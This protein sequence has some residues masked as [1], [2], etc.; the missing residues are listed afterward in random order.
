M[1]S[2][3]TVSAM[4][5]PQRAAK[6]LNGITILNLD[7]YSYA[8]FV[9]KMAESSQAVA[10]R[11]CAMGVRQEVV[12]SGV[13]A[14]TRAYREMFTHG[15]KMKRICLDKISA[16]LQRLGL[17]SQKTSALHY[18]L[19]PN[20]WKPRLMGIFDEPIAKSAEII[21]VNAGSL[22]INTNHLHW[23]KQ[24]ELMAAGLFKPSKELLAT[25]AQAKLDRIEGL[26]DSISFI[27]SNNGDASILEKELADALR[28]QQESMPKLA[29]SV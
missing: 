20:T 4:K 5:F 15:G 8:R 19:D 2:I 6:I 17:S 11:L 27:K 1:S 16:S 22:N 9:A 7:G 29:L 23:Y 21:S 24:S 28:E 18:L 25:V 12:T 10:K 14:N 26:R 3:G 13:V